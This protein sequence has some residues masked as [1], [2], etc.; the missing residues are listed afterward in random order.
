[1]FE[2]MFCQIVITLSAVASVIE[3]RVWLKK[4][5]VFIQSRLMVSLTLA[6]SAPSALTHSTRGTNTVHPRSSTDVLF[7]NS[8]K[9]NKCAKNA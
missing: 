8:D 4:A 2:E 9:L 1:M 6:A 7:K 5:E 3:Q